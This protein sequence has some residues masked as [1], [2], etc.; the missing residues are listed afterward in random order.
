M[1]LPQSDAPFPSDPADIDGGIRKEFWALL[2]ADS[3]REARTQTIDRMCQK[4]GNKIMTV[5]LGW[6][7]PE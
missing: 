7:S 6:G 5:D 2:S 3:E 1:S 4:I